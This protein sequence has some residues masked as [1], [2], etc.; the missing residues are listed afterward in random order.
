MQKDNNVNFKLWKKG[1]NINKQGVGYESESQQQDERQ[2][3]VPML[4]HSTS[5]GSSKL[6][7]YPGFAHGRDEHGTLGRTSPQP[8]QTLG[9]S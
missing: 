5:Q 3:A 7:Q 2:A 1:E 4:T 6:L 9:C 8:S